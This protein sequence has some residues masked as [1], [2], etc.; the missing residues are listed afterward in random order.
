MEKKC[1]VPRCTIGYK[2]C[3]EKYSL[4]FTREDDE[5]LKLRRHDIP[6]KVRPLQATDS[7]CER[8]FESHLVTKTWT[9]HF[10]GNVLMS[11]PRRS[12]LACDAVSTVFPDCPP[13]LSKRSTT[14]KR[15]AGRQL[16]ALAKRECAPSSVSYNDDDP[17]NCHM[18]CDEMP[19]A[20][21]GID[22]ESPKAQSGPG[23]AC[24]SPFES[25]CG[26]IPQS[27]LPSD[28]WDR[29]KLELDG[30]KSVV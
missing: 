30:V 20:Q 4:F 16:L 15:P 3:Q 13:Y 25:L 23:E 21:A 6:R 19:A 18:S 9:A 5:R 14:Q 12:S 28:S 27:F 29:H 7:V 10:N 26:E 22:I 8:H 11:M 24:C 1:F 17:L 2:S